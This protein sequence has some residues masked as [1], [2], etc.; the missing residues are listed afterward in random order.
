MTS[1]DSNSPSKAWPALA[2]AGHVDSI[3]AI[4]RIDAAA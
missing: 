4:K 2:E 1:A 3:V